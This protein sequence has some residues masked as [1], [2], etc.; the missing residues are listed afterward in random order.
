[1]G[2]I[3]IK[4]KGQEMQDYKEELAKEIYYN[5]YYAKEIQTQYPKFEDYLN[6]E[7]FDED[8]QRLRNK[9]D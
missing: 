7:D 6:S 5:G 8:A 4:W 1:M 9:F 2:N 3:K